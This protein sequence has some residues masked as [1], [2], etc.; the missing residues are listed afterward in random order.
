MATYDD[1]RGACLEYLRE[2]EHLDR[3]PTKENYKEL[4]QR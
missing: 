4:A 2:V 3:G 1:M